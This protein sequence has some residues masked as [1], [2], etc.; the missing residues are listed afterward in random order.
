MGSTDGTGCP[1]HSPVVSESIFFYLKK[2][3]FYFMCVSVLPTCMYVHHVC[4]QCLR[5]PERVLEP[6]EV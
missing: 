1:Q 6:L 3:L 5:R 4:T 2:D